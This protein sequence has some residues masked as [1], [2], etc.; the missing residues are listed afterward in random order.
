M[1]RKTVMLPRNTAELLVTAHEHGNK[2]PETVINAIREQLQQSQLNA[3]DKLLTDLNNESYGYGVYNT[4]NNDLMPIP[5]GSTQKSQ[6]RVIRTWDENLF[7][8]IQKQY[9]VESIEHLRIVTVQ[10]ANTVDKHESKSFL[11]NNE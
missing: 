11:E 5:E 10:L 2:P 1:I 7:T 3:E 9:A 4:R 6:T 8:Q